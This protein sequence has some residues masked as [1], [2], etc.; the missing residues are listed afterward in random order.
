[1]TETN[2]TT[3][4][5]MSLHP[6]LVQ[7]LD[8]QRGQRLVAFFSQ[9]PLARP[10]TI[11]Q[12]HVRRLVAFFSQISNDESLVQSFNDVI[13]KS[14]SGDD[15][16]DELFELL[17]DSNMEMQ[18]IPGQHVGN[19]IAFFNKVM[20]YGAS[21]Q[22][23]KGGKLAGSARCGCVHYCSTNLPGPALLAFNES[24]E[25]QTAGQTGIIS[26]L[27]ADK[28]DKLTDHQEPEISKPKRGIKRKLTEC[29]S[30]QHEAGEMETIKSSGKQLDQASSSEETSTVVTSVPSV[31]KSV[32]NVSDNLVETF[33]VTELDKVQ[34]IIVTASEQV[35]ENWKPQSTK[36]DC[37]IAEISAPNQQQGQE[38][39]EC[40]NDVTIIDTVT[41]TTLKRRRTIL[42]RCNCN[43]SEGDSSPSEVEKL[44]EQTESSDQESS[45]VQEPSSQTASETV[46]IQKSE[47]VTR[48]CIACSCHQTCIKKITMKCSCHHPD[49][50]SADDM[51]DA[52]IS[53]DEQSKKEDDLPAR[54][55]SEE[56]VLEV[57]KAVKASEQ[58]CPTIWQ[59]VTKWRI[60]CSCGHH[61]PG[62]MVPIKC[63]CD[64]P[65]ME[66]EN[67]C[68][69]LEDAPIKAERVAEYKSENPTTNAD[70]LLQQLILEYKKDQ[71]KPH[72]LY[73]VDQLVSWFVNN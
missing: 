48:V 38:D 67:V 58:E 44:I 37:P 69:P 70:Q 63:V 45:A 29:N 9:I 73:P 41:R 16:V 43:Q 52:V 30:A 15:S 14:E 33:H 26:E 66:V 47:R 3:E 23:G 32:N 25:T 31:I 49:E 61:S 65:D 36:M 59:E 7:L 10:V 56:K 20:E 22:Y 5:S 55:S 2:Y 6:E 68:E 53:T 72:L 46:K 28:I 11:T 24:Q 8:S 35:N 27:V 51:T 4:K 34:P 42:V 21:I 19:L 54:S 62:D 1:M 40:C 64:Y 50:D 18:P 17:D 71:S 57:H 13:Q 39:E 60:I 12:E